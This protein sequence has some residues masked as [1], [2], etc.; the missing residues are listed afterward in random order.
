MIVTK[1]IPDKE[2]TISLSKQHR[3]ASLYR[4]IQVGLEHLQVSPAHL[5]VSPVH[6]RGAEERNLRNSISRSVSPAKPKLGSPLLARQLRR[7]LP[8]PQKQATSINFATRDVPFS[9]LATRELRPERPLRVERL[10]ERDLGRRL[11]PKR[12]PIVVK[13]AKQLPILLAKSVVYPETTLNADQTRS[14]DF[15]ASQV[16]RRT[17]Y[18]HQAAP[19]SFEQI[20]LTGF[21]INNSHDFYHQFKQRQPSPFLKLKKTNRSVLLDFRGRNRYCL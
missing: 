20:D 4:K 16:D 8:E 1:N 10:D 19:Q 3:Y 6:L 11:T 9:H 13:Y 2:S 5:Q 17:L 18:P 14:F 7:V 21:L 12:G 15:Q